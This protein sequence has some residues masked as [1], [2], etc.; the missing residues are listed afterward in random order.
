MDRSTQTAR[1]N[2]M[3]KRYDRL[4]Q[5]L[6]SIQSGQDLYSG[7]L[8]SVAHC[9]DKTY[10]LAIMDR[11]GNEKLI[12]VSEGEF[13]QIIRPQ[14]EGTL[15]FSDRFKRSMKELLEIIES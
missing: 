2:Y 11:D 14:F 15:S 12:E 13:D 5:H 3:L 4:R 10:D 8:L 9:S 6:Y 1:M 7:Y